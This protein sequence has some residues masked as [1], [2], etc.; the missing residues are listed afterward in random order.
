MNKIEIINPKI[1]LINCIN[2]TPIPTSNNMLEITD[3]GENIH[4]SKQATTIIAPVTISNEMTERIPDGITMESSNIATL[5]ISGLSKQARQ[6]YIFP[7]MKTAPFISLGVLCDDGCTITLDKQEI[8]VQKNGQ[9]IIKGTRSGSADGV[10]FRGR[11]VG[12]DPLDGAGPV[13]LS[14]QG[15]A[16][17]HWETDE[18]A[19]GWE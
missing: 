18:E 17:A 16:E 5:Q 19:G 8:S 2:T 1:S 15:C 4:L 11:D 7:K 14:A 10:S 9:E 6:I 3:S 12:P 13:Q